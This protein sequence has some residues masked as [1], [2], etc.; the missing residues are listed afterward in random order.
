VAVIVHV[1]VATIVTVLPE[2]VQTEGVVGVSVT[3]R[4]ELAV[5]LM[6]KGATPK[7][8][9]LNELNEMVWPARTV[10]L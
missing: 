6:P 5:A 4:P 3:V 10:K 2:I 8:T 1:P 9:L 7:A